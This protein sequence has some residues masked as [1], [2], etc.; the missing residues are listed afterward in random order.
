MILSQRALFMGSVAA[1][2][3]LMAAVGVVFGYI[4]PDSWYYILLAQSLRHGQGCAV[5]GQYLAVYPCGYPAVLAATAPL[6][7]LPALMISSKLTNALLL[8]ASFVFV[9]KATR[10]PLAAAFLALNP[11]T[12]LL[13]LYTWSENLLLF[14]T[15]G[16]FF[17]ISR[18]HEAPKSK[19][20]HALLALFLILGCFARY[21]FGPFAF[22][23]FVCAALAYGWKTA[24]RILPAFVLAGIVYLAY[25]RFNIAHTG[26]ATG[27]GRIAAPESPYLIAALFVQAVFSAA[28]CP[29]LATAL[30]WCVGRKD[31]RLSRAE[32]DTGKTARF[33]MLSGAGFLALAFILRAGTQFD[34][35]GPRTIGY[36]LVFAAAGLIARFVRLRSSYPVAG[37]IAFGLFSLVFANDL[38]IPIGFYKMATGDYRFPAASLPLLKR[39]GPPAD[40][41]VY[42]ELPD[43]PKGLDKIDTI[44]ALHYPDI[45]LVAPS[46]RPDDTPDTPK[47]FLKKVIEAED[48][49]PNARC[50]FDF[51]PFNNAADFQVYINRATQTD[52]SFA[53]WPG[54]SRPT[55]R[56]D[57]D[58]ALQAYLKTIVQP[59][60]MVPCR[61]ILASPVARKILTG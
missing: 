30:F 14:C 49:N 29:A 25:Q 23:L 3:L 55:W 47:T 39:Q 59:G 44:E 9:L 50:Y 5:G 43:L 27:M 61:D 37:L 46:S 8:G 28:L 11:I 22:I 41:I 7:S 12:L 2:L 51:T 1:A 20:H 19:A 40:I 17:A 56:E 33:L 35:F 45:R 42:F 26:Y 36:G 32:P 57:F 13:G 38:L 6:T 16:A 21:V 24:L 53:L 15:C 58:P 31:L 4:S 52:T 10:H 34:P 54:M 18:L 60:Q 48:G